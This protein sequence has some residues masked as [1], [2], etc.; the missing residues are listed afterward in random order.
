MPTEPTYFSRPWFTAASLQQ[1]RRNFPAPPSGR[2]RLSG[3]LSPSIEDGNAKMQIYSPMPTRWLTTMRVAA[4]MLLLPSVGI[5]GS[6]MS[7]TLGE[8]KGGL[9]RLFVNAGATHFVAVNGSDEGPG[10]VDRPRSSLS[11]KGNDPPHGG[12][13]DARSGFRL[14]HSFLSSATQT[15]RAQARAQRAGSALEM[16]GLILRNIRVLQDREP[17]EV[18]AT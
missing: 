14:G 18:A 8:G 9:E 13:S 1:A 5:C 4:I 7:L 15:N 17:E 10:T 11:L 2:T 6:S 16:M 12:L 3:S